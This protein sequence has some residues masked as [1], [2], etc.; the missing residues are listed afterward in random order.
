MKTRYK[1]IISNKNL[2]KEI[3]LSPETEYAR[4]GTEIDCDFRLHR[5]LFFEPVTITLNKKDDRWFMICSDNLYIST[6]DVRKLI[7]KELKHGDIISIKYQNSN[8]E[9]F[10]LEF[11]IDFNDGNI[12][13]ERAFDVSACSTITIGTDNISNIVIRSNYTHNDNIVL[14]RNGANFVLSI[15]NTFNG[16][17]HNGQLAKNGERINNGDFLSL[18]DCFFYLKDNKLWTEKGTL[19]S[20]SSIRYADNPEI[21]SY[22]KFARTTRIQTIINDDKIEILDPPAKQEKPKD[23]L[24]MSLLPSV[25][26]LATAGVMAAFG[27][28]TMIIFSGISAL[29]A[30]I[31]A[32]ISLRKNKKEHKLAEQ[33]R[34]DQYNKYIEEKRNDISQKREDE[35]TNLEDIYI[36][37]HKE[38]EFF[39]EFSAHLFDRTFDDA[40]FLCVRLGT[41]QVEARQVIDYKKQEKLEVEDELQ[42]MPQTICEEYKYLVN[43]PVFCDFK[44]SDAVGIIGDKD[45]VYDLFKRIVIDLI[46]RH[47]YLDLGL[48]FVAEQSNKYKVNWLRL[49]PY[50]YNEEIGVPNIVCDDES[51]NIIFEYLYKEL[52]RR[53]QSETENKHLVVFLFDEYG[54]SKHPISKFVSQAKKLN[55]TFVFFGE[56]CSKIASGCQYLIKV[57]NGNG[58][59]IDVKNKNDSKSFYYDSIPEETACQ[60]VDFVSPIYTEDVSLESELTK[61]ISL[62]EMMKILVVEDIDL[63]TRWKESAVFKSMA[64]PIG[65]TK[66]DYVYLDLHDKAH[67]PHGLVAGTTGS[68]KSEILQTYILSIATLFHPYEVS[69]VIIDFKGGGMVN[70][71]KNLPHLLGAI[72]NIDGKE[73]D[74]SLKSIKAEL[75]KRQRLFAE[76]KVNHID[77]YIKKYK[78]GEVVYPIPHLILIVDEFAELKAE[79]PDFMKEL[80][81]AA[82][83]GR[84]LGVHL[85]LATQKPSGQVDDQIWSNSRFKLCLKVQGVE[86][87]NEVLK[88][89]LA[90]EIKEPG[91]AYLQVG[92]N[93]IFELFQSAYSGA[94]EKT[95]D[96]NEKEFSIIQITDSARRKTIYSQKRKKNSENNRTQLEAIVDH[97]RKYCDSEGVNQLPN[98]CLPP[99]PD[100]IELQDER[101]INRGCIDIG[102]YDDPDNQLQDSTYIDIDNKNTLIIGSSQYGKTNLLQTIIKSVALDHAPSQSVFY[103]LDFGSMI[104]KNYEN[105]I[106]VGGVVTSSEDEKLKNLF[107]LLLGE[108]SN[109]KERLLA[110]GVS[111]FASYIEAGYTD[112]PQIYILIDNF[113]ALSELYLENDDSILTVMREGISFGIS[114]IVANNQIS[115]I[116]YKYLSNFANKLVLYCNDSNEYSNVFDH[117]TIKPDEKPGRCVLEIDK[118]LLE[119]QTYL[120]FSGEKEIDRVNKM[121]IFINSVNSKYKNEKVRKIPCIPA[122]LTEDILTN[123]FSAISQNERIPIALTYDSVQP[124]YIDLRHIGM[125][126]ITGK[127]EFGHKNITSYLLNTLI[128]SL[129]QNAHIVVIDDVTRKYSEYKNDIDAYSLNPEF[130]L[131]VLK[132]WHKELGRRYNQMMLSESAVE[133]EE[134]LLMVI[135]NNDVAK[136]IQ[137]NIE[138]ADL[139]TEIMTRYKEMGV[140]I[141]FANYPNSNINYDSPEPLRMVKQNQMFI[142]LDDLQNIKCFDPPYDA[143][144]QYKKQIVV[145]DGYF[146][147]G[148]DVVKLKIVSAND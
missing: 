14:K 131:E 8:N 106:H 96:S 28:V 17:Y 10:N 67:G 7:T 117:V 138:V 39:N 42:K 143:I 112:L 38:E 125:L 46:A 121:H 115:G 142:C 137:S 114:T 18:S 77:K 107:K 54:F 27:G 33:K 116:G 140:C 123:E 35:L 126:G 63:K 12:K 30:I 71:F 148:N 55:T 37:F 3:E 118:R 19:V 83:I 57:N 32:F 69:F 113:T 1:I 73:I 91:R 21:N 90:A 82:R 24:L 144:R 100:V 6:G 139:F 34:I 43:A 15:K 5:D 124:F 146:V 25:G 58:T 47:H 29:M 99:L 51:R 120:A 109:R 48:I 20:S 56:E 23:N 64:A 53:E 61:N 50:V 40:D 127:A 2:Y 11:D 49:L 36:S 86:D 68:G 44:S 130:A 52:T 78:S 45:S 66:N 122:I 105:L 129:K 141:L 59:L 72:T 110:V 9:L 79:Q 75:N 70:Q 89:P 87:S 104:L 41:G 135:Q 101:M 108:I 95:S 93:E 128:N 4:I 98:I 97:V 26:M 85:I 84:S 103:I 133:S 80:I 74:R 92:N 65:V 147:N 102:I 60:I 76:A 88:S 94:P 31:T 119:C 134:L 132:E 62:F 111:S 16:V 145:G 136:A 22:P 81:S 13:Y